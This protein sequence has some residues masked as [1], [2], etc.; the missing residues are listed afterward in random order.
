MQLVGLVVGVAV[1]LALYPD[2]GAKA[3]DVV[4]PHQR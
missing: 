2:A 3:D 4:I 1:T